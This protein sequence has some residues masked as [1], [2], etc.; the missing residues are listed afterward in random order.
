[1]TDWIDRKG[2]HKQ[3]P[4]ARR[5]F[6][7]GPHEGLLFTPDPRR[8]N[9]P[10]KILDPLRQCQGVTEYTRSLP[11]RAVLQWPI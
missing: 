8:T 1:M 7:R 5:D 3:D 2:A 4:I 10:P 11:N 9:T 6:A